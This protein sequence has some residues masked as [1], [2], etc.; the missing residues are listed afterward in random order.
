VPLALNFTAT[1]GGVVF[2]F[3]TGVTLSRVGLNA[4]LNIA[5]S[6]AE[7]FD[8]ILANGGGVFVAGMPVSLSETCTQSV[9]AHHVGLISCTN[10]VISIGNGE[11]PE[12]ASL[13]ILGAS[14]FG[15]GLLWRRRT[16]A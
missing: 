2:A 9:V 13:A 4:A 15:L 14:L 11:V 10:S 6:F 1:V 8:G 3:D 7:Q 16:S 5:G 12:P